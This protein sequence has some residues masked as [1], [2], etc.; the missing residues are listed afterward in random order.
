MQAPETSLPEIY[1]QPGESHLVSWPAVLRT[2]LGSCVGITFFV[3]RLGIG[4]LCHPMLPHCDSHRC[5]GTEEADLRRFV[6]FA[7]REIARGL[8]SLGAQRLEAQVKLFGGCDV[9]PIGDNQSRPT[10]GHLN[11]KAALRVLAEEGF[12]IAASRLGGKAGVS[13]QFRTDSGEVLL[14][15]LSSS[16]VGQNPPGRRQRMGCGEH[17][18]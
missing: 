11:A 13:I 17:R 6:D 5:A 15:P 10:V 4:A 9:L 2:V 8:D 1:V 7:I 16:G 12:V 18:R 14:I 3:P